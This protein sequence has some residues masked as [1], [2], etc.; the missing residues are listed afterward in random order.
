[1]SRLLNDALNDHLIDP[2][3]FKQKLDTAP[4]RGAKEVI[5]AMI[6]RIGTGDWK[7]GKITSAATAQPGQKSYRS[8]LEAAERTPFRNTMGLLLRDF[9]T[10]FLLLGWG[11][12]NLGE[13]AH[14]GLLVEFA[15][16]GLVG[17][18]EAVA[19]PAAAPATSPPPAGETPSA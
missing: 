5:N 8:F 19:A 13:V 3:F 11:A 15:W 7:R 17:I 1:M 2:T 12:W 10:P 14:D 9:I 16:E 6:A 18:T 4:Y